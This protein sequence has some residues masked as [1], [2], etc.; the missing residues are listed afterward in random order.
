LNISLKKSFLTFLSVILIS[1]VIAPSNL[2]YAMSEK[3]CLA[4][5]KSGYSKSELKSLLELEGI[6]IV[7]QLISTDVVSTNSII[8]NSIAEHSSEIAAYQ[9]GEY[10]PL[11]HSEM[12]LGFK[13]AVFDNIT[14]EYIVNKVIV[15]E[16]KDTNELI[17]LMAWVDLDQNKLLDITLTHFDIEA[18][19]TLIFIDQNYEN[20]SSDELITVAKEFNFNGMAFACSMLGL[21]A[22][23]SYC[24][25]WGL[26]NVAAGVTCAILCGTAFNFACSGA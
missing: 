12:L 17:A 22:C 4:C 11:E 2:S 20:Q 8:E 25:I 7:E 24:G 19:G 18:N 21:F 13:G 3:S 26:V 16:R 10:T 23:T 9:M 15:Y 6:E 1:C 5:E 14:Y